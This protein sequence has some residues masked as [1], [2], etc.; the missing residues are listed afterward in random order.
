MKT[1]PIRIRNA[2]KYYNR[3]RNNQLHVMD[4]IN[5]ELPEQGMVAVFGRSGC[6]KTT[7]L[8]AVGG[9]DRIA[10]GSIELF[11]QD[12]RKNTDTL[13]NQYV[14]YIFQNYYLN[15]NDTIFENVAAAL[16]LCGV[17]DE[18]LIAQRVM[19]ALSNVDMAKFRDRTPDTLSGGQQQRVAI[20][21][22]IVKA[23]AILLCD[24]PT[25]NLDEAN[26]VLVM[27]ILKELSKSRLVL[28][29]THEAH[30]VDHYCDRVIEI[31]DGHIASDRVNQEANGYVTRNKNHIYLGELPK[32][33]TDIPGVT[34]EYYGEPTDTIRLR[35]INQNGKLYLKAEG[36]PVKLLDEGSEIKLM[37][38][39]FNETPTH[40]A[41]VHGKTLDM[42]CLTPVEGKNYGR[43]YHW[44]N[45]TVSAWRENFSK[46]KKKGRGLLRACLLLL[47]MVLV[48]M[49]AAFGAGLG[50]ATTLLKDHNK[51]LFYIPL[52]PE[53]NYTP[54][55]QEMSLHGDYGRL[56]GADI[57]YSYYLQFTSAPFMTTRSTVIGAQGIANSIDTLED[58]RIAAGTGELSKAS[59][60][61]IT[62]AFADK[63]I[64]S[65]TVHYL[66]EYDDMV[67]L[68]TA[69]RIYPL[70]F[71]LRIVGVVESDELFFYM[72]SMT[73][74]RVICDSYLYSVS[75]APASESDIQKKPGEGEVICTSSEY[76]VGDKV[77]LNG[78]PLT[79]SHVLPYP[80]S[81]I[82]LSGYVLA[83]HGRDI[84]KEIR[85]YKNNI[86]NGTDPSV[87][88]WTVLFEYYFPYYPEY[89]RW[90]I[91][92]MYP[93]DIKLDE[94]LVAEFG[95]VSAFANLMGEGSAE[96]CAA[97]LYH[98]EKGAYPSE[99]E[100][101]SFLAERGSDIEGM[102]DYSNY[103]NEFDMFIARQWEDQKGT[104]QNV[105]ILNDADYIRLANGVGAFENYNSPSPFECL[106]FGGSPYYT[107]HFM[108]HSR[109]SEVTAAYL[110]E[111]LGEDGFISPEDV[112][113]RAFADIRT[114]VIVAVVTVLAVIALMCLCVYFIMRS[115]FMSRVREVGIQR[116]IG[117]SEK[118]LSFRFAVETAL[119]LLLT[120]VPGYLL[121]AWFI[122]SL[123]NAPLISDVFY[124]PWWLGVLLFGVLLSAS[125]LF[126]LIPVWT[127]LRKTPSEILSKYDI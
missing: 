107:H 5:L 17:T 25:G 31:V 93:K 119:L 122:A 23:P 109:D 53:K 3:G 76:H 19:T 113:S 71:K 66:D 54:L 100:L 74:A 125:L 36:T 70:D 92:S 126:G 85:E 110:T 42:S 2:H 77:T 59:D 106:S 90:R 35:V 22:A 84:S 37:E 11:G 88:K 4:N 98:E 112:L 21:R 67:N 33:Q 43:L 95:N 50:Q 103:Y 44:K 124:F 16:R 91:R 111:L 97:Y 58:P 51:N 41:S 55:R 34:V 64:E 1:P 6:G 24:E 105:F 8:N 45:A 30:L 94:W 56:I 116:A 60:I 121:S 89:C 104:E 87:T 10:T 27:D 118:N 57:D 7:L 49:T 32:T 101:Y 13:R 117:V 127:L 46:R 81:M 14:G 40:L 65:A 102:C 72:D 12:I 96:A 79:V 48:F 68:V 28:L 38:G 108:I 63:L 120:T 69:D 26:T 18:A 78:L 82:D 15:V 39:V 115:S 83:M 73:F 114:T 80:D 52:D 9:L 47:A 99:M 75:V 61:L 62:T 86:P 29:V 20:A 123:R